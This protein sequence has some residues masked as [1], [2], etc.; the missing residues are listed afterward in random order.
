MS[1]KYFF[2]GLAV[3][4]ILAVFFGSPIIYLALGLYIMSHVLTRYAVNRRHL[5][6]GRRKGIR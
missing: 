3:M 5:G 6:H 1:V 2:A 4:L